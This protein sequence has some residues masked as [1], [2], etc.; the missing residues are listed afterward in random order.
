MSRDRRVRAGFA[1]SPQ[2]NVAIQ[3]AKRIAE[4]ESVGS[5]TESGRGQADLVEGI[6]GSAWPA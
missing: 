6:R 3:D 1:V 2:L 4:R 5:S